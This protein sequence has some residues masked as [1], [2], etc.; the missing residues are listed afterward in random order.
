M[1]THL[2]ELILS[3]T[4]CQLRPKKYQSNL[5]KKITLV[6]VGKIIKFEIKE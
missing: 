4:R 6:F 5:K 1:A 3:H 2:L